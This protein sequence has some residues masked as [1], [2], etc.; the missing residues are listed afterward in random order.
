MIKV[1]A[2]NL[3]RV[4]KE[5]D[6]GVYLEG[7]DQEI[8]LPARFV[9]ANTQVGDELEVFLYHDSENRLIATTQ[10]PLGIVGDIVNLKAVS[11]TKQGAFL[12]WGLMKDL[13]VAK[14]Q[15]LTQMATGQEYLVKIYI[16]ELTGR[17][18]AT[19]K[20]ERFL[21]NE[22]LT[23]NE[24]DTVNLIVYRRTDI[25]YVVIINNLHTGILHHSEIFRPIDIGDQL[26]GFI[27]QIKGDKIDVVIGQPGFK[28]V[29]DEG[30][31][32]LRLLQENN[33]YLPYHDKSTP[34]EI[35]DF[36]G[37]SKKTFK[38]TIGNLYKQR[39]VIFTQTGLKAAEE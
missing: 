34:E 17:I 28:R 5:I 32:I 18:A 39:K 13:F 36:F 24:L 3:L 20:I 27:R 15:Q 6:F 21:S 11:V 37:M 25:G 26:K 29:E 8:L 1:G 2:Y 35:Q 14:S 33:G 38:M 19:E 22:N 4:K 10:R 30:E 31:K 9:P 23:V 12:D 16:D 7:F